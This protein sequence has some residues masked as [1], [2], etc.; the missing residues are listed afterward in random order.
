MDGSNN[1][2]WKITLDRD[3][4]VE[5]YMWDGGV[6]WDIVQQELIYE[7]FGMNKDG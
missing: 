5:T 6:S 2:T 7:L 3:G 1:G 4:V